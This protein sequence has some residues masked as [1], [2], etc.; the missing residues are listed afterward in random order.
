MDHSPSLAELRA[1]RLIA[2]GLASSAARPELN[3][4][5]DVTRHLLALQGQTYPA[6]IRAIALRAGV[7]DGEVLAAVDKFEIVRAW[8]QRGT[9][10][11]MP[12]EDTR[13][14]MRSLSP[15]VEKAAAGRRPG[16]GLSPEDVVTAR[17]ALHAELLARGLRDPL[18]RK[19][20]YRVFA[21]AG[22]DPGDGRG[23]HLLRALGGEGDVVQGPK[24]G[25]E[26]T[27]VHVDHLPVEQR[28]LSREEALSELAT[29]YLH[30]H[31]PATPKDLV[32]WSKLTVAEARKAIAAARDVVEIELDGQTYWMGRWQEDV[33]RAEIDAALDA[34]YSLPA[35]DEYLLGYADK[36][37]ILA[38]DLRHRVLTMN[39]L[40]WPFE[41]SRGVVTGRTE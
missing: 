28:E 1:R 8:P 16:L 11:F 26:E 30:S 5:T 29:R 3:R 25:A 33:T 10:H 12:P 37:W 14:M 17:Q 21:E 19:E 22:V 15:R 2:Q 39:G 13:W 24:K 7:D 32:W 35:F 40:S 23:P 6:G 38:P 9:L 41:V 20:A 34:D 18:P 36:S 4:P 27:F 31:G